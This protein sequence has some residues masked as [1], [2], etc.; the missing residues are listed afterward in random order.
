MTINPNMPEG[1][2]NV[3]QC[4]ALADDQEFT[5]STP[6]PPSKVTLELQTVVEFLPS[7]PL[8]LLSVQPSTKPTPVST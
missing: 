8:P 2:L 7:A 1:Q 5:S 3:A 6:V 4:G